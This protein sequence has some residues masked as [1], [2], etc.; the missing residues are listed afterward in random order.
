MATK[1]H[2]IK[3]GTWIELPAKLSQSAINKRIESYK[4]KIDEN[5]NTINAFRY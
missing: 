4:K 2:E 5:N 3:P 1:K